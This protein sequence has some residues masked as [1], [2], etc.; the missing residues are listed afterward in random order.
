MIWFVFALL[1]GLAVVSVLWPLLSPVGEEPEHLADAAF[2]R[3]QI[4]EID[5]E[6]SRG[7]VSAEEGAAARIAA[8]RRLLASARDEAA[9][10]ASLRASMLAAAL[11]TVSI[12]VLS[13]GLYSRVGHPALPDQPLQARL[14]QPLVKSDRAEGAAIE[15]RLARQPD[16]GADYERLAPIYLRAGRYAEAVQAR[17]EALRLLGATPERLTDYAEAL[18]YAA[19]GVM[20]PEAVDQL[21]RALALDPRFPGARYFLGLAAAQHDDAAKARE[22]WTSMLPDLPPG[23]PTRKNVEE[24]LALLDQPADAAP[25]GGAAVDDQAIRAMVDKMAARLSSRGGSAEEWRELIRSYAALHDAE[26]ARS[27]LA[28]AEKAASND[29]VAGREL[30]G[31]AK[32]LGFG[33]Q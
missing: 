7:A 1:T 16:S 33:A 14:D 11:A 20:T 10:P 6:M 9:A 19:E 30:A 23:S 18:A 2:Y 8:A 25:P 22:I 24:K 4:D 21:E 26:K 28:A 12:P 3:A 15:S 32:E 13:L 5:A 29:P 27:A 31:L 17:A